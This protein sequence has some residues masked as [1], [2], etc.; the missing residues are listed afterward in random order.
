M[1]EFRTMIIT[2][3]GQALIAKMLAGKGNIQFTKISLSETAYTDTQILELGSIGGV[4]QSTAVTKITKTSDAAVQVEGAVTNSDLTKGYYI[5]TIALHAKDPD[6]GEIV[7]AACGA[8]TPGWMPPYNGV[9][10]SDLH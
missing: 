10:T 1:A 6:E 3:K 4:K 7:Y 5:R 9:S 2:N 8:S